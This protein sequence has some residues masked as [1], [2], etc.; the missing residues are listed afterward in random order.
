MSV[1]VQNIGAVSGAGL[2][3]T[4]AYTMQLAVSDDL[5]GRLEAVFSHGCDE[6]SDDVAAH[7]HALPPRGRAICSSR[8]IGFS[9]GLELVCGDKG[10]QIER[11]VQNPSPDTHEPRTKPVASPSS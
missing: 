3:P 6:I 10:I 1:Q 8:L 7:G 5:L 4:P 11:I 9:S 2:V